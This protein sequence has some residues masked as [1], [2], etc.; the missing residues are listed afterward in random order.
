MPHR[1]PF[2]NALARLC[3]LGDLDKLER[4]QKM[5]QAHRYYN[6]PQHM[7]TDDREREYY[8]YNRHP[9]GI[10]QSPYPYHQSIIGDG[11]EP[12]L[13]VRR[14]R[15]EDLGLYRPGMGRRVSVHR[16]LGPDADDWDS[17][18]V[19]TYYYCHV[20]D[21]ERFKRRWKRFPGGRL[22]HYSERGWVRRY[23]EYIQSLVDQEE[24]HMF[25]QGHG[26]GG[27]R[28][29]PR[30]RDQRGQWYDED[31]DDDEDFDD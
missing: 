7:V 12:D 17:D 26:H 28:R 11:L 31:D 16:P 29:M 30:G 25:Q 3:G 5:R 10:P 27:R 23:H 22:P 8:N 14:R 2:D 19:A 9:H 13:R 15:A 20:E 6:R 1:L 4:E 18:Q 24:S 21:I